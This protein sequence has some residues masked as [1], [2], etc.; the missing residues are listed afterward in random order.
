MAKKTKKEKRRKNQFTKRT[1]K[2]VKKGGTRPEGISEP[3]F[4]TAKRLLHDIGKWR[5]IS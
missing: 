5:K 1:R 2:R 4:P 3:V